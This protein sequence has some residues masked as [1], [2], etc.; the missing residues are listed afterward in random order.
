MSDYRDDMRQWAESAD[1]GPAARELLRALVERV[2]RDGDVEATARGLAAEFG[3]SIGAM[4][5]RISSLIDRQY[6]ARYRLTGYKSGRLILSVRYPPLA[7]EISR[8]M[9]EIVLEERIR[10][11]R[12]ELPEIRRRQRERTE[13]LARGEITVEQ[14]FRGE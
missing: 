4:R 5:S 9:D 7:A 11:A 2:D 10:I 8:R 12:A 3:V 6:L 13:R 14:A 1:L